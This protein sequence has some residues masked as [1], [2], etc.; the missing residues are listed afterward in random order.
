MHQLNTIANDVPALRISNLKMHFGALKAIDG[1]N[2]VVSRGQRHALLGT[3]G[4]GKTTLFNTIAGD[5][6]ATS[7][8]I[9]YFGDE[10]TSLP[11][12]AR[13]GLGLGR[14]YQTPLLFTGLSVRQNVIVAILG[15][16]TGCF[17]IKAVS[18]DSNV[19]RKATELCQ[20]CGLEGFE[21]AFVAGLSHGQKK[22]LELAM[23]LAGDPKLLLLDEPA[24]GLSPESRQDLIQIIRDLPPDLTVVFVEHDMEVAL[25]L[26]QVVTVMKDGQVVASGTSQE[27]RVNPIVKGMY[28]GDA[29]EVANED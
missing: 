7:G 23:A 19:S 3:N 17:S 20:R 24:A 25:S 16:R 15:S 5:L 14:T 26:A 27:V 9:E 8:Q 21:H 28:L 11:P 1:V 22:Q 18:S 13:V 6:I 12:H 4:A 2:L 29:L 10:I